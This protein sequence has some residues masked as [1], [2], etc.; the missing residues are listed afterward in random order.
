[1]E[2]LTPYGLAALA[3]AIP[4]V[5][6][7]LRRRRR[8]VTE[9]PSTEL[10]RAVQRD[11]ARH[12]GLRKLR[13]EASLWLHL[14]ALVFAALALAA[15][16]RRAKVT[17]ATRLVLVVDTTASMGARHGARTRL[18]LARDAARSALASLASDGRVTLV[19]AGCYPAITVPETRDPREVLR[20]LDALRPRD[21]GGDLSRALAIAADRIRGATGARRVVVITDGTTRADAVSV[22]A[23]GRVE[24]VLVGRDAANVG[25]TGA[26]LRAAPDATG[27]PGEPRRFALLVALS[28]VGEGAPREVT[29]T[30]EAL[31]GEV[32]TSLAVRRTR[33]AAGRSAVSLPI[34]LAE[35]DTAD[36]L[37]VRV[38]S[39]DD[40]L[41]V[42]DVAW[43]PV[44]PSSRVSVRLVVPREGASPWVT[45]ALR[46]DPGVA[47]TALTKTAWEG[48]RARPFD[49]LTVFHGTAPAESRA[50]ES[51]A[52]DGA[53]TATQRS[54][55]G[56][57]LGA[58]SPLPRWTDTSPT[59]ARARFVGVAD[60]HV[61]SS[62][63]IESLP[64]DIALVTA[65]TGPL[66]VARD[67]ARGSATVAAFDPDRSDWPLRPGFVLFLRAAVEHARDRSAA[68]GLD[69]RRTGSTVRI[70]VAEGD[71]VRVRGPS[72]ERS[73]PVREGVA[74]WT[75]TDRVGV[76]AL[77]RGRG[78][79]RVGLSLLD[80]VESALTRS[81]LPWRGTSSHAASAE[82][83]E[84]RE[85]AWLLALAALAA[86]SVEWWIF[87]GARFSKPFNA[88]IPRRGSAPARV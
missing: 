37:R 88:L 52:F 42:D 11:L 20:A 66:I 30:A 76:Y 9:V 26:E 57:S 12:A 38:E 59:D 43:A 78:A 13:S 33:L 40:S 71:R 32:A 63:A 25:I 65:S 50:G 15:P 2:L 39:E 75:D 18:D 87:S 49:G 79:E 24:V 19:E 53:D 48:L 70:P 5:A 21:C 10:W 84:A 68:L 83:W 29:L 73:L 56:V 6:L 74:E 44:P 16:F 22:T 58:S 51:L 8:A 27:A 80:P 60:V 54:L 67:T 64:G 1:M 69:A 62:R 41:A 82:T 3:L 23:S 14:A 61:S 45:R 55:L 17:P 4:L 81:E 72:G 34:E 85:L 31:R 7:Y 77:D 46:A 86:L 28:R 47:L 35:G 36:L